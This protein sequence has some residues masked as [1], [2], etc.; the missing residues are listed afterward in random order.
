LEEYKKKIK[1]DMSG[2]ID[3]INKLLDDIIDN[4][5]NFS[6]ADLKMICN[7]VSYRIKDNKNIVVNTLDDTYKL[8]ILKEFFDEYTWEELED[9]KKKIKNK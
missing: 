6:Q 1:I 5:S 8:E 3:N 4:V 7:E 9:I 2:G